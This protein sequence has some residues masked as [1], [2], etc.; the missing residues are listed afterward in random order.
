MSAE[1]DDPL[2][3]RYEVRAWPMKDSMHFGIPFSSFHRPDG[4]AGR[5]WDVAQRLLGMPRTAPDEEWFRVFASPLARGQGPPRA[6]V[7]RARSLGEALLRGLE[8]LEDGSFPQ[9]GEP[10]YF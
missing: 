4:I 8:M 10:T 3:D 6:T 5:A 9:P 1:T 2:G 7:I